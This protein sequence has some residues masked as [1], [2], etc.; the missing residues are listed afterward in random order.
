[1]KKNLKLR[2]YHKYQ[3]TKE[4]LIIETGKAVVVVGVLAFFFYR[5]V[6][7]MIPLSMV[8]YLFFRME[9][10]K[11]R[12]RC[13]EELGTQF[14]ECILS[15]AASMQAGYA[16]ENA[17]LE[18][19]NDMRLL[20]G[21]DSLIFAELENIRR[22]LMSNNTLEDVLADLA[23]RSDN[24]DILQFSQVF[25]I[26]KRGGGNLAEI[27]RS[28]V[29]LIGQRIDAKKE[30]ATVLSGRKLEQMIMKCM[31]FGILLYIGMSYPGY[32]DDLYHNI[33]GVGIMTVCMIVY[34][35]AY[36]MGDRILRKIAL[37]MG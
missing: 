4:E 7:A 1:M 13:K 32:F 5:S 30:I 20:Y 2:D 22:N 27:I 6:W 37:E 18:S 3:W 14:K 17:F 31:P 10:Q 29:D 11:K 35:A 24:E 23:K 8:G 19:R 33:Q 9:E 34:L 28:T 21:D 15:V 12:E 25:A 16:V 26:A 36:A